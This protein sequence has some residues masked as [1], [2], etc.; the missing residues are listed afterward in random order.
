[1][2]IQD[3]TTCKKVQAPNPSHVL[4]ETLG[5]HK[6]R[7]LH[8]PGRA[9]ACRGVPERVCEHHSA[10]RLRSPTNIS[11]SGTH[12]EDVEIILHAPVHH[13]TV[14]CQSC[15]TEP[16]QRSTAECI[17]HSWADRGCALGGSAG[18]GAPCEPGAPGAPWAID[19]GLHGPLN[20]L[21]HGCGDLA[22]VMFHTCLGPFVIIL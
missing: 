11:D 18:S 15:C 6:F 19:P 9:R 17:E 10:L 8:G 21:Q 1:M 13:S 5:N 22:Q 20:G 16:Q 2:T 4:H 7:H 12:R 14:T 3:N